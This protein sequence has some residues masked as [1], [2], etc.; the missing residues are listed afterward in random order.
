M[1]VLQYGSE[2]E[3]LTPP[4]FSALYHNTG[5]CTHVALLYAVVLSATNNTGR[6][7][8]QKLLCTIFPN[9]KLFNFHIV[10]FKRFHVIIIFSRMDAFNMPSAIILLS[11][12]C[13]AIRALKGFFTS[14]HS[15]MGFHM[16]TN[17]FNGWAHWTSV[18][19]GAYLNGSK[20]QQI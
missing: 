6:F 20:L 9:L 19:V 16:S 15:N 7:Y 8:L 17:F 3:P 5:K 10:L 2:C 18:C 11:K 12:G 14:M 13:F 1:A 4:S